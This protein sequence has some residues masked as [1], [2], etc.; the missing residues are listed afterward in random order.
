M[1]ES[2]VINA[3]TR[4][5][6]V[7]ES[8][9]Q[10]GVAGERRIEVRH[11]HINGRFLGDFDLGDGFRFR[12]VVHNANGEYGA[13]IIDAIFPSIDGIDFDW[14]IG[15][16]ALAYKGK[17]EFAVCAVKVDDYGEIQHEWH[18][19]A[20]VG[21]VNY[22]IE[23]TVS[24][25]GGKDLIAV[26]TTLADRVQQQT[27]N[28]NNIFLNLTELANAVQVN[29]NQATTSAEIATNAQ[30]AASI[31]ASKA[32]ESETNAKNSEDAAAESE[33]KATSSAKNAEASRKAADEA[34]KL[35]QQVTQGAVGFY[36]THAALNAAHPTGKDG[37]WAIVGTTD[38]VWVWD[39]DRGKWFDSGNSTKFADYYDKSQIDSMQTKLVTLTVPASSWETGSFD[40]S[41][42]DGTTTT[43]TARATVSS[44]IVAED[45]RISVSGRTRPTDAVRMIAALE[46]AAGA[47]KFYTNTVSSA[48]A[49]L[50]MEVRQ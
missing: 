29:A 9:V 28:A 38:T 45:S 25:I 34:A 1:S 11:F 41:W 42:D 24:N 33:Q 18:S 47:V 10:L 12:V 31:S 21:K 7:P 48:D 40:V 3:E 19:D 39:S 26:L 49:V 16:C 14:L 37:N 13:D 2:I 6:S 20:G 5:I 46:P 27:A 15:P 30:K 22:G 44:A 36:P 50:I 43:Y 23:A 4:A 8:E 35:A 17:C 32:S